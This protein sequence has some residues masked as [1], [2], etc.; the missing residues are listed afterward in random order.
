MKIWYQSMTAYGFDPDWDN[1]GEALKEQ[2]RKAVRSDTEVHIQGIPVAVSEMVQYRTVMYYHTGALMKNMYIA[3]EQGY[4]AFVN[5]ASQQPLLQEGKEMLD[6]PVLGISEVAY[7]LACMLGERFAIVTIL[8]SLREFYRQQISQYG[9]LSRYIDGNYI[10][11]ATEKEQSAALNEPAPLIEKFLDISKRAI[12]DG[13]SVI[14]PSPPTICTLAYRMGINDI[15]GALFLDTVSAVVK[16][17]EMFAELKRI[18]VGVSRKSGIY[19]SPGEELLNET[20]KQCQ[21][22]FNIDYGKQ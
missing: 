22:I 11:N 21:K 8:P 18:G 20:L 14:I 15:D 1:Y 3:Q 16:F 17:A 10:V 2:C 13:A 12:S 9:L 19:E 4:D 5:G 7:Y 6:I